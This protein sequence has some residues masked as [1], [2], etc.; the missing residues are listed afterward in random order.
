MANQDI[1]IM[2]V[3]DD[4]TNRFCTKINLE[5][6]GYNN[7]HEADD[8]VTC[9]EYLENN[10][11]IDIILLDRMM[12][13]LNGV[14]TLRKIRENPAYDNII[15]MFQTGEITEEKLQECMDAGSLYLIEKPYDDKILFNFLDPIVNIIHAKRHFIS[16]LENYKSNKCQFELSNFN[17]IPNVAAQIAAHYK[18]PLLFY[19]PI[20]QL[21]FNAIEH[22]NLTIGEDKNFLMS[23]NLYK[24]EVNKRQ[25]LN[26]KIVSVHIDKNDSSIILT[27]EDEGNGFTH[28]DKNGFA[29]S[30]MTKFCGRG[31]F[32]AKSAFDKVEFANGGNKIICTVVG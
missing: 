17:E 19:E 14:P 27:I 13:N 26:N 25:A 2:V 15:V 4:E 8:G 31:I 10:H 20:Y 3:D 28:N 11:D 12:N 1:N 5:I 9:L 18:N 22:G 24:N 23:E 7:F 30:K 29:A 21:L 32:K 6:I 16:N